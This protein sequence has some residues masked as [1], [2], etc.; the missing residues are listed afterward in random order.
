MSE[1]LEWEMYDLFDSGMFAFPIWEHNAARKIVRTLMRRGV[2]GEEI[3]DSIE[4]STQDL[5]LWLNRSGKHMV[6]EWLIAWM[7]ETREE[8]DTNM[9]DSSQSHRRESLQAFLD[10]NSQSTF[11]FDSDDDDAEQMGTTETPEVQSVID[12]LENNNSTSTEDNYASPNT[13][14]NPND[15][16]NPTIH[17]Q[18]DVHLITEVP[19]PPPLP[20]P[21]TQTQKSDHITECQ[22]DERAYIMEPRA[23]ICIMEEFDEPLYT[24]RDKNKTTLFC[25]MLK[26]KQPS[27][28]TLM[29]ETESDSVKMDAIP[30]HRLNITETLKEKEKPKEPDLAPLC[31]EESL[32]DDSDLDSLHSG[33]V[34]YDIIPSAPMLDELDETPPPPPEGTTITEA[35]VLPPNGHIKGPQNN[36][37]DIPL[38]KHTI[39]FDSSDMFMKEPIPPILEQ[40]ILPSTNHV[41]ECTCAINHYS[42]IHHSGG[43]DTFD[44]DDKCAV[45]KLATKSKAMELNFDTLDR[46]GPGFI[47]VMTDSYHKYLPWS[48][49]HR[50]KVASSRQ[51][52]KCLT[53]FKSRNI[54][55]DLIWQVK[56]QCHLRAIKEVHSCLSDY[57]IQSNWFKCPLSVIMDIVSKIAKKYRSEN[58]KH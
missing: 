32:N 39:R 10:N 42:L 26:K 45:C 52:E 34:I 44:E 47:Y 36:N 31:E 37:Q 17:S 29:S 20:P 43:D 16:S 2:L 5:E 8:Y 55:I 3:A 51:P 48:G 57:T 7:N 30:D 33:A 21:R 49:E 19:T 50:Y 40:T 28:E 56:V 14:P 11:Q 54:E 18:E 58:N 23:P 53:E 22:H 4:E 6:G 15:N 27:E 46:D 1:E 24:K 41:E 9:E 12:Y 13:L 38:G 35:P 25:S